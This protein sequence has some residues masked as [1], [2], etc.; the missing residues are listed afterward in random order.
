VRRALWWS[1]ALLRGPEPHEPVEALVQRAAERP[2]ASARGACT[3]QVGGRSHQAVWLLDG[4]RWHLAVVDELRRPQ[5]VVRSDGLGLAVTAG[6]V[7]RVLERG[8]AASWVPEGMVGRPLGTE[9]TVSRGP[10]GGRVSVGTGPLGSEWWSVWS[11]SGWLRVATL[12]GPEGLPWLDLV[13]REPSVQGL[14]SALRLALGELVVDAH[15]SWAPLPDVPA[16]TFHL[17]PPPHHRVERVSD[18]AWR[19]LARALQRLEAPDDVAP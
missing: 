1:V 16:D 19:L 6:G 11:A 12:R 5:L 3:L 18:T 2:L 7:H 10:Q 14:P 15:C 13:R 4:A 9:V 17:L 8:G